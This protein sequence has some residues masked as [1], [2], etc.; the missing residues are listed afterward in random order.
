MF[1]SEFISTVY[2]G[3]RACKGFE[4]DSW[5]R[6]VAIHVDCISRVRDPSGEWRCY[7]AEDIED[8]RLVFAGVTRIAFEPSGPLPNDL[9]DGLRITRID[10]SDESP[11]YTFELH[12]DSVD[13]RGNRTSVRMELDATDLYVED[14]ARPGLEIRN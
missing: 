10:A 1:P 11:V 3:D 4:I 7:T 6:R 14:P 12:V 8:G 13:A 2:L 5:K 9:L